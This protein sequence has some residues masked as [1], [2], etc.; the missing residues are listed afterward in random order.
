MPCC[1]RVHAFLSRAGGRYD[2]LVWMDL[3]AIFARADA[4]LEE[5]LDPAFDLHVTA[6]F[7]RPDRINT[8]FFALRASQ[9]SYVFLE[10]V[11]AHNDFGK[12][13]SDQASINH[14]ISLL[15]ASEREKRIKVYP[16]ELLNAFPAVEF[17]PVDS[18]A[19]PS[20]DG[21]EA[22]RSLVVHFAGQFGGARAYDGA[23]T[24]L[25]LVQFLDLL[26]TRHAAFM[27][28]L[29]E[30]NRSGAVAPRDANHTA[31]SLR[32]AATVSPLSE[33]RAV[34]DRSRAGLAPC[35]A[36]LAAYD[37][38]YDFHLQIP[39]FVPPEPQP[40]VSAAC[41]PAPH[42][43][44]LRRSLSTLLPP[45][46]G[47]PPWPRFLLCVEPQRASD[48]S[49]L[50]AAALPI[51]PS[52]EPTDRLR[53]P[54]SRNLQHFKMVEALRSTDLRRRWATLQ[55]AEGGSQRDGKGEV[56]DGDD[57]SIHQEDP[58]ALT[59]AVSGCALVAS[60]QRG[61]S[62]YDATHQLQHFDDATPR[63][64]EY[65]GRPAVGPS[66]GIRR[67][68]SLAVVPPMPPRCAL[69][70]ALQGAGERPSA[71]AL[72]GTA[73]TGGCSDG[74]ESSPSEAEHFLVVVAPLMLAYASHVPS[75]TRLLSLGSSGLSHGLSHGP[76]APAWWREALDSLGLAGRWP[77][78]PTTEPITEAGTDYAEELFTFFHGEAGDGAAGAL[79]R[80]D[81]QVAFASTQSWRLARALQVALSREPDAATESANDAGEWPVVAVLCSTAPAAMDCDTAAEELRAGLVSRLGRPAR[82]IT[83]PSPAVEW[84]VAGDLSGLAAAAAVVR[85]AAV[86]VSSD[87][88]ELLLVG[89]TG[90]SGHPELAAARDPFSGDH[91][92][93][94]E[95]VYWQRAESSTL[96]H[97]ARALAEAGMT[98]W[99]L[100]LEEGEGGRLLCAA[101]VAA[102][103]RWRTAREALGAAEGLLGATGHPS[104]HRGWHEARSEARSEARGAERRQRGAFER[105]SIALAGGGARAP[106]IAGLLPVTA[107]MGPVVDRDT[108]GAFL[109]ARFGGGRFG[110]L[111]VGVE[112]GD[113]AVQVLSRWT[114]AEYTLLDDFRDAKTGM[115]DETR[116]AVA[117]RAL[118]PWTAAKTGG[119]MVTFVASSAGAAGAASGSGSGSGWPVEAVRAAERLAIGAVAAAAAGRFPLAFAYVDPSPA[120][121]APALRRCLEGLW[122]ALAPGGLLAGHDYTEAKPVVAAAV[123][124]FARDKGLVLLVTDVQVPR[125]DVRGLRIPPCC[126]SWYLLK[127]GAPE[128][129]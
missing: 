127:E 126:P 21:D 57:G 89:L 52:S 5:L 93:P 75:G 1:S 115:M 3:D 128:P 36:L 114:C 26:L 11:W 69:Q 61:A 35:L 13:Q 19:L 9:W 17:V 66:D 82:V 110:G 95:I 119:A 62:V 117:E 44:A 56:G 40:G 88:P 23:T 97:R 6:D 7:G 22:A 47:S 65:A 90:S 8:G 101:V 73:T 12:G 109:E 28:T 112:Y 25:M 68:A 48:P 32:M 53:P 123:H 60:G 87:C 77:E 113:L 86:L 85:R 106:A 4:S 64:V 98:V 111:E 27:D 74:R 108:F 122:A 120:T 30:V 58:E 70:R 39:K 104:G 107:R 31:A 67:H 76:S 43:T 118:G 129:R 100:R 78:E 71:L 81:R 102:L 59:I 55:S 46:G 105:A 10:Q 18:Y 83:V 80:Y 92:Q 94:L 96:S 41:D 72:R 121:P 15:S 125:I 79:E 2:W 103:E 45:T 124:A 51:K 16:R 63:G 54:P 50:P 34:I 38:S 37:R 49:S 42:L 24:P 29:P 91:P 99:P 14:C 33:A 84:P 116:R 20:S